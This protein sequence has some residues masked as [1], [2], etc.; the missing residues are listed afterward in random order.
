M[1][2][3]VTNVGRRLAVVRKRGEE[4]PWPRVV[5]EQSGDHVAAVVSNLRHRDPR[6]TANL[7]GHLPTDYLRAE[8][9]RLGFD[10]ETDS[11]EGATELRV[12]LM[13]PTELRVR[14]VASRLGVHPSTIYGSRDAWQG[15]PFTWVIC[16]KGAHR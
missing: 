4:A 3:N 10:A 15:S 9:D 12:P 6:M 16:A 2:Q 7:Y 8:I 13:S 14:E 1:A 5:R 11:A